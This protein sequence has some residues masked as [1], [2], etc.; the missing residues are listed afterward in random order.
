MVRAAAVQLEPVLFSREQTTAKVVDAIAEA[1]RG[2]AELVVFPE[3]VVPYYPYFSFVLPPVLQGKPHLQLYEEAVTVPGPTV[4]HGVGGGPGGG[5][6]GAAG[7][8]RA[9]SRVAV[10][11]AASF[12]RR[13]H[14]GA[15]APQDHADLPRAD[16]VGSGRRER[17]EGG[18]DGGGPGGGAGLLGALQPAGPLRVDGPARADPLRSLSGFA[19]GAH[20]LR[21][22]RG[23]AASPRVGV[24]LLRGERDGAAVGRA[25][26]AGDA[27]PAAAACPERGLLD[28]D[29]VARG[30]GADRTAGRRR[31]HRLRRSGL[32]SDHQTQADDGQRGALRPSGTAE[33]AGERC[34]GVTVRHDGGAGDLARSRVGRARGIRPLRRRR[35]LCFKDDSP[36]PSFETHHACLATL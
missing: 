4:D 29:R 5:H 30:P 20:L 36:D 18:R 25:E 31:G 35:I 21:P 23:D 32:R 3:T 1:G 14:A 7:G 28:H 2:G 15:E 10:Q 33:P 9:G 12:R 8:D 17:V 16:G 26:G 22:D 19:G 34:P 6:G 24:G 27:G 11:H 13:R